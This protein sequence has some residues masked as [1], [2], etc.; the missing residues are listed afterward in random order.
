MNHH[1]TAP[2]RGSRFRLNRLAGAAALSAATVLSACTDDV[3]PNICSG[4]WFLG[5]ARIHTVI[6]VDGVALPPS[7]LVSVELVPAR[8]NSP[9]PGKRSTLETV[10]SSDFNVY[11]AEE[12]T[13]LTTDTVSM[14]VVGRLLELPI[15]PVPN[16][17]FKTVAVDSVLHVLK[18]SR[19]RE[20]ILPGSV[21]LRL[22]KP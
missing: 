8:N 20:R 10:G 1:V 19:L 17:P 12:P 15:P 14:W 13:P 6:S 21:Q 4:N 2:L 7:H 18:V 11:F 22:H 9:W 5:C 3:D 16:V